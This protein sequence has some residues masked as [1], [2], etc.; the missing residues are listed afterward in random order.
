MIIADLDLQRLNSERRRMTTYGAFHQT[1]SWGEGSEEAGA[2]YEVIDFVL[3]GHD[4]TRLRRVIDKAPFVPHQEGQRSKRC[5]EILS[6]QSMGLKKRLAHTGSR[7]AVIGI[8]G[9]L[10]STLAL[11]V[12][13]RAFD[14][15]AVS[16][17]H[18]DVYK[19]QF[20]DHERFCPRGSD[21]PRLR[22][23]LGQPFQQ[24]F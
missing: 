23:Y 14:L 5:E 6:I 20:L 8:S 19:R 9:G 4:K 10:D 24:P 16:Y 13:T 17:T 7:S 18:L 11:L 15:L 2:G 21:V 3:K 12:T 22:L 1:S